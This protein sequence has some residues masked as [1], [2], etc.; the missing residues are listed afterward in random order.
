MSEGEEYDELGNLF[1]PDI[2][3][4]TDSEALENGIIFNIRE[5]SKHGVNRITESV[6]TWLGGFINEEEFPNRYREL[7]DA[8]MEAYYETGDK[9]LVSF[10]YKGQRFW[11][12]NNEVDGK[13]IMFPDDY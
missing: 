12:M 11:M 5:Y 13:T 8:A 6:Y 1:G 2:S 7:E 3:R 4:F 10:Q 9:E